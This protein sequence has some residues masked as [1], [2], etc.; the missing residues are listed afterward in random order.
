MTDVVPFM[1]YK[2]RG[3]QAEIIGDIRRTLDEGRHLVMESGTGTGKTIVS[4]AGALAHARPRGKKIVYLTRT[5][6]QSDQVMRELKAISTVR[7]VSGIAMAGRGKSCPLFRSIEDVDSIPPHVQYAMC[8]ERKRRS[9]TGLDGGCVFDSNVEDQKGPLLRICSEDFPTTTAFDAFCESLRMCPYEARR[10]MMAFADVVCVPYTYIL[11]PEIRGFLLASMAP[12]S[13]PALIVPIID[14][15]HNFID[16]ARE[17]ESFTI[18]RSLLESAEE[19]SSGEEVLPGVMLKDFISFLRRSIRSLASERIGLGQS[20]H[21]IRDNDLEEKVMK[22]FGLDEHGL[23]LALEAVTEI[24]SHMT[25]EAVAKGGTGASP[26][27]ILGMKMSLWCTSD[28]TRFVRTV[29]TGKDGEYLRAACIGVE[30]ISE[31]LEM[32]PGAIHMSGTLRPLDQYARVLNLPKNARFR[33][34]PSPFPPENRRIVYSRNLTTRFSDMKRNPEMKSKLEQTIVELCRTTS[35]NTIVFFTSYA[36]MDSMRRNIE[37]A[38]N[39]T[40]YWEGGGSRE[41]AETVRRFRSERG[42]VLFSVMGGSIA[43][44]IDFPGDELR[45]A[46]IVGIP[47]PPPSSELSE[48]S[49]MMDERYGPGKGWKYASEVPAIRKVNQAIGRLIRTE[50]DTGLAVI[51]DSRAYRYEKQLD[52]VPSDDVVTQARRFFSRKSRL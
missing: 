45:F 30:D 39:R 24:G 12:G 27:E 40:C 9:A 49:R 13:N 4:L 29:K 32:I 25:E 43:E 6:S 3:C 52:A 26:I 14:E 11:D 50:T 22:R 5:I 31:F 20:E 44:G 48:I 21:M 2:P 33:T 46:I 15:A 47:F 34:Y 7:D 1:P 38:M 36:S 51:L 17:T 16:H 42:G 28:P 10:L 23:A 18:T 35:E 19:E 41:T 37:S 8:Q